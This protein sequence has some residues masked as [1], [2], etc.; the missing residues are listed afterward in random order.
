[1]ALQRLA[2]ERLTEHTS[3]K[4]IKEPLSCNACPYGTDMH[5]AYY[6]LIF[7]VLR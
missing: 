6:G 2:V 4:R 7:S 3:K 1:M 5:I